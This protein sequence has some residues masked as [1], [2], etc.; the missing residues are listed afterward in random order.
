MKLQLLFACLAALAQAK[1]LWESPQQ[2]TLAPAKHDV[3]PS[4]W[5]ALEA[6]PDPVDALLALRPGLAEQMSEARLLEVSGKEAAWMTEGD[7]LRLRREGKSFVDITEIGERVKSLV[8]QKPRKR[9]IQLYL[10]TTAGLGS[11]RD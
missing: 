10:A 11:E 1:P 7:K 9:L 8:A 5:A 4:I 6:H 3:D 2:F